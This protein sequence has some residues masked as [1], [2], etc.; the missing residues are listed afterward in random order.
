VY[1]Y[2][3]PYVL[4]RRTY[5]YWLESVDLNGGTERFGPVKGRAQ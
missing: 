4:P 5:Y 3:D 1:D 2:P